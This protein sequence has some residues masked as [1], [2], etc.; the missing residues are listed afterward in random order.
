MSAWLATATWLAS[1]WSRTYTRSLPH[2]VREARRAE[3]ASD[4]HE[5]A[6]HGIARG[7]DP[8]DVGFELLVRVLFGVPA[9]L[10][11]RWGVTHG[12]RRAVLITQRKVRTMATRLFVALGVVLTA[13]AGVFM[14]V[15]GFGVAFFGGAVPGETYP[16]WGAIEMASGVLMLAGLVVSSRSPRVGTT[17]VILGVLAVSVTHVWLLAINVPIAIVLI[18]A[19]IV[20]ARRVTSG[21]AA[22]A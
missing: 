22:P 8:A 6:A 17:L 5:H 1:A 11:W 18:A 19:A 7:D 16:L 3:I 4:V 2:D 9:D 12:S 13:L 10:V 15:N 20:R 21:R 14:I